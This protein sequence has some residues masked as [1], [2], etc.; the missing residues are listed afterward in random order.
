MRRLSG[1]PPIGLILGLAGLV[2]S[3]VSLC[4]CGSAGRY[5][6]GQWEDTLDPQLPNVEYASVPL[7]EDR[8]GFMFAPDGVETPN[9]RAGIWN[10]SPS[11]VTSVEFRDAEG[12]I[13]TYFTAVSPGETWESPL[14]LVPGTYLIVCRTP[15]W[16][17]VRWFQFRY[18]VEAAVI[19]QGDV[20][21]P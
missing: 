18:G 16:Q 4:S 2:L 11:I 15:F 13:A 8:V 1:P 20:F 7:A 19:D 10:L 17:Y 12:S 14:S 9:G 5:E 3:L 21:F 6:G